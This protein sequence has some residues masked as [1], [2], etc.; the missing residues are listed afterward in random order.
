MERVIRA[1]VHSESFFLVRDGDCGLVHRKSL[2][3]HS[4]WKSSSVL[5]KTD[6]RHHSFHYLCSGGTGVRDFFFSTDLTS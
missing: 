3:I 1:H 2:C 6:E 5:P 4:F